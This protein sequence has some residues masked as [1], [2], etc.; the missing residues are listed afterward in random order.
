MS[1]LDLTQ[2]NVTITHVSIANK[3]LT[4]SIFNQIEY[5]NC[6]DEEMNFIGDPVYGYVKDKDYRYLLWTIGG[7]LRRT[8]LTKY[9]D[10]KTNVENASLES[11]EWFLRNTKLEYEMYDDYRDRLSEG[12]KDHKR[13]IELVTKSKDFL[14]GLVDKQIYL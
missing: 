6:F 4:K 13:Y 5:G 8:G 10:L 14:K 2:F 12:L 7:K 9:Y 1:G 11:T 3:K